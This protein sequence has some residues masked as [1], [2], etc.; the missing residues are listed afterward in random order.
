MT[1]I[2]TFNLLDHQDEFIFSPKK[3]PCLDGGYGNG[4]STAWMIRLGLHCQTNPGTKTGV[5]RGELSDLKKST[6]QEFEDLYGEHGNYHSLDNIFTWDNGSTTLFHQLSDL[7]KLRNHNFSACV[8]EQAE[9]TNEEAFFTLVGRLRRR[10]TANNDLGIADRW[11]GIASNPEGHD[12]IWKLW[13]N[14][15]IPEPDEQAKKELEE[16]DIDPPSPDDFHYICADSFANKENLSDDYFQ[17]LLTMPEHMRKKYV[18]ASRDVLEGAIY[19]MLQPDIQLISPFEIPKEWPKWFT[20]DYGDTNPTAGLWITMDYHDNVYVYREHYQKQGDEGKDWVISQHVDAI[21]GVE[22]NRSDP[23]CPY[24]EGIKTRYVDPACTAKNRERNG[25]KI[26]IVE[27]FDQEGLRNIQPWRRANSK[28]ETQAQINRVAEL[29]QPKD[30]REF[31]Q[32]HEQ[33]RESPAPRLY[34]MENCPNTWEEHTQ[35]K[36]KKQSTRSQGQKNL[37]DVPQDHNDHTC[38]ALRGFCSEKMMGPRKERVA[39]VGSFEYVRKKHL[40]KKRK[41]QSQGQLYGKFSI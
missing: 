18:Y 26:S 6:K 35:W 28:R 37:P 7:G 1:E 5:F 38:D 23:L 14:E 40:A 41:K 3:F 16:H 34:I 9:E 10:D 15:D 21:K 30:E 13:I 2:S 32:H 31:P 20:L 22:N 27:E 17:G 11:M 33:H 25:R 8:I 4:K 39:P 19:S 24:R 29:F 36:W 12:W